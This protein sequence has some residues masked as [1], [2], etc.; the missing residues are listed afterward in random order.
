MSKRYTKGNY[1]QNVANDEITCDL[2][3]ASGCHRQSRRSASATGG[4]SSSAKRSHPCSPVVCPRPI[5]M[6]NDAN[7]PPPPLPPRLRCPKRQN[8]L[9]SNLES[10]KSTGIPTVQVR[11]LSMNVD[12][13]TA[14]SVIGLPLGQSAVDYGSAA[15]ELEKMGKRKHFRRKTVDSIAAQSVTSIQ[16]LPEDEHSS[17]Y[18]WDYSDWHNTLAPAPAPLPRDYNCTTA[19]KSQIFFLTTDNNNGHHSDNDLLTK[20]ISKFE[21]TDIE[22]NDE[23]QAMVDSFIDEPDGNKKDQTCQFRRQLIALS[24]L[25]EGLDKFDLNEKRLSVVSSKNDK[26]GE[27]S[28]LDQYLPRFNTPSSAGSERRRSSGLKKNAENKVSDHNDDNVSEWSALMGPSMGG[29]NSQAPM[30]QND[31]VGSSTKVCEIVDDDDE[32]G[33]K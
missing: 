27:G 13:E 10:A 25:N 11:P 5:A 1:I 21:E 23:D 33:G 19:D 14:S 8:L 9:L 7:K 17:V 2:L 16:C 22:D 26:N 18:Q 30:N 4:G 29:S 15:E 6:L 3:H 32:D 24:Q 31:F 28:Y 20:C 12:R